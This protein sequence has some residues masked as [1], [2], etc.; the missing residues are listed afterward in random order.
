MRSSAA[1]RF[2]G[3]TRS[4]AAG[5]RS[6][7]WCSTSTSSSSRD[8]GSTSRSSLPPISRPG[9]TSIFAPQ[10]SIETLALH[11]VGAGAADHFVLRAGAARA[12]DRADHLAAVHE[13]NAAARGDHVV[14]CHEVVVARLDTRLEGLGL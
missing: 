8:A 6:T 13:R 1:A 4:K 14:E 10:E 7:R 11:R 2:P 3:T 5:Q 9:S 12:A